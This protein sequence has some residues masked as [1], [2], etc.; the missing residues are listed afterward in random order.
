VSPLGEQ[1]LHSLQ[2]VHAA[3]RRD[4]RTC[5]ELADAVAAGAAPDTVR[6]NLRAL[7]TNGPLWQLRMNCLYYCTFVHSHHGAEDAQ[8]FPALRHAEPDLI[9]VVDKL[10]ADHRTVSHLLDRVEDAADA[11]VARDSAD[12]RVRLVDALGEL[13]EKLLTHLAFEEEAVGPALSRFDRWP[14]NP[15]HNWSSG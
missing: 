13:S 14:T 10:E 2:W 8:L 5:R 11:L 6:T 1:L 7:Q 3:I 12:L 4:L 15:R 9:P